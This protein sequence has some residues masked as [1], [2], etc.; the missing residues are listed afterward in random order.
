MFTRRV[1]T[2]IRVDGI[3]ICRASGVDEGALAA[4]FAYFVFNLT[5]PSHLKNTL[6][7]LQ[8]YVLKLTVDGDKPLPTPVTRL[9]NLLQ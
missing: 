8:R 1:T 4:F 6:M 2:V 3:E 7:F 5:C 9:I